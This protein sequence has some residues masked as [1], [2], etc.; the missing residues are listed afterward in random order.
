MRAR[1]DGPE[2]K[3]RTGA[4]LTPTRRDRGLSAE[5]GYR[6]DRSGNTL[7]NRKRRQLDRLRREQ[8]RAQWQSKGERNLG[9]G[10]S[11]VRRIVASLGL[12]KSIRD[13]ACALFRTAHSERLCQGG[14]LEAVAVA[15]VYTTTRCNGLRRKSL[16][17]H[18][19]G[20]PDSLI[21]AGR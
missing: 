15:S 18:V 5:I 13:Q 1:S 20:C 19:M 6:R 7:S 14:S 2:S 9:Y 3:K 11:E 10:L 12:A 4:P 21:R 17:V 8:S 16:P